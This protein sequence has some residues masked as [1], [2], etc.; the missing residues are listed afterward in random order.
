MTVIRDAVGLPIRTLATIEDITERKL[1]ETRVQQAQKMEAIG[2]LAGGVAH[3]FNNILAAMIMQ[4]ELA[5]AA[6]DLPPQ[7]REGLVEI[8]RAAERAANLTRQLLLFGR[9]QVMQKRALDLN[10]IVAGLAKML[11]RI[12]GEDIRLQLDLHP[13][14]LVVD[15]D[16]GMLDQVVMNLAVNARDAMPDGGR[17]LI[18]TGETVLDADCARLH[19]EAKP[20]AHVWLSVSDTGGGIPPEVLPRIFEPFFTTK[21]VGKG[22]GLGLATVFGIVKQ[23]QGWIEVESEPGRGAHFHIFLPATATPAAAPH[24]PPAKPKPRGGTETIF[25]VEDDTP[26]RAAT[27]KLLSRNGYT[28]LEAANGAEALEHWEQYRG[29]VALLLTDLVMPSGV[30]GQDLARHLRQDEPDLKIIFTSG[31]SAEIAARGIELQP[32]QNFVQKPC[33]PDQLLESIRRCL[34]G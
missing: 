22:T 13:A 31:Y 4:A 30:S 25:V 19:A 6:Q 28:V 26:L 32:G 8:R 15:A 7:A 10:E 2:Q 5:A 18:E 20:G 14:A 17:L 33:P 29:R 34:D 16:A 12:I 11:Q 23:H 9:R 21:E 1:L 27:R 3:D 24:P